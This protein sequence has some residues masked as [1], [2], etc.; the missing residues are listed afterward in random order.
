VPGR[1][2]DLVRLDLALADREDSRTA[3]T[4]RVLGASSFAVRVTRTAVSSR[5]VATITADAWCT[6][7][8]RSTDERV[9]FPVT[10]TRP[11]AEAASSWARSVSTTTICSGSVPSPS[12][13]STAARPLVP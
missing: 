8:I 3:T 6:P 4:M 10:V 2:A 11:R 12:R 5:F 1:A 13:V 9:A 7:A